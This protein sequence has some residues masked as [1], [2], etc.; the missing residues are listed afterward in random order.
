[1]KKN[2]AN[3]QVAIIG[4]GIAGLEAA[5]TLLQLGY[6]PVILE[7]AATPGGHVASWHKLFPDMAPAAPLVDN[8]LAKTKDAKLRLQTEIYAAAGSGRNTP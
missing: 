2:T 1:M 4:A 6:R 7:K 3:K 5:R 8:L